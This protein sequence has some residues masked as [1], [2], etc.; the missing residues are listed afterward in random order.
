VKKLEEFMQISLPPGFKESADEISAYSRSF[1]IFLFI[2]NREV[3][4]PLNSNREVLVP[5]KGKNRE[6]L[7]PL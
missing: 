4:I 7:V 2:S 3:L 1:Q 6:V 5:F